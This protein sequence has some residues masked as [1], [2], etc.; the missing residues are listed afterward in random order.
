MSESVGFR[1]DTPQIGGDLP[2]PPPLDISEDD[3]QTSI[4][5]APDHMGQPSPGQ[6][7]VPPTPTE[8]PSPG[9]PPVPPTQ[10]G[11]PSPRVLQQSSVSS[12][13]PPVPPPM[14]LDLPANGTAAL[15]VLG[16]IAGLP[17][18]P[19]HGGLPTSPEHAGLP[20]SPEHGGLPRSPVHGGL[21][22][23]PVHGGLPASSTYEGP[24]LTLANRQSAARKLLLDSQDVITSTMNKK[25]HKFISDPNL[26]Y[27]DFAN[28]ISTDAFKTL[29][30]SAQNTALEIMALRV[31]LDP[32]QVGLLSR[33]DIVQ[34]I[35]NNL[36]RE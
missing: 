2:R 14:A 31:G 7:P 29:D 4:A 8:Q 5:R 27:F 19:A 18:I 12:G 16:S 15:H 22:R 36:S 32:D 23:S 24:E 17:Y 6:P 20:V 21:P 1:G 13:Q 10:G 26:N 9:Q 3:M 35:A 28:I 25:L 34:F 30:I 11:Q 33:D